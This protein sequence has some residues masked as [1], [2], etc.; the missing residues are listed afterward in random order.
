M[1]TAVS[2]DPFLLLSVPLRKMSE[3]KPLLG[4]CY[5]DA[6]SEI[7]GCNPPTLHTLDEVSQDLRRPIK[8]NE[9]EPRRLSG[10]ENVD[11]YLLQFELT[12]RCNGWGNFEKSA[13]LLCALGGSARGRISEFDDPTSVSYD[14]VKQALLRRFGPTQL[15]EVHEQAL[16]QLMLHKGQSVRELA[17]EVQ[18]LI[19]QAHPVIIGPPRERLAAKHLISPVHDKDTVFYMREKN[20]RDITEACTMNE[21]YN[22]LL[23]KK[24]VTAAVI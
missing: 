12:A 23:A 7:D 11:E 14:Q 4:V 21:R 22:A 19:K 3:A 9:I 6:D 24:S 5:N 16:T 8:R 10:K 2:S 17:Q 1:D 13:A 15:V 20:P 18:R